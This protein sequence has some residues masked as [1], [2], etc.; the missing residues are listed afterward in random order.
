VRKKV[1]FGAL[2]VAGS[3]AAAAVLLQPQ[4]TP[5][6]AQSPKAASRAQ[7]PGVAAEE[8]FAALPS[9]E[10][11]GRPA[12]EPFGSHSWVPP[13]QA[14]AAAPVAVAPS[15]PPMPYRVAGQMV[16]GGA[17]Q[18][19]LAKGDRVLTVREGETL[20][21]GYRVEAIKADSV[22]LLYT[23]MNVRETLPFN[24]ALG[25]EAPAAKVA[26]AAAPPAAQSTDLGVTQASEARPAQLRWEG[27]ER[28]QAGNTFNVALKVTSDQAVRASPLQVSYDAALLE[29]VG[30]RAG[31]FF[32]GGSFSY[33]IVPGG[34]IMVGALGAGEVPADAE[35]LVVTFR[36]IRAGATADVKLSSVLLQG[37]AGRAIVH[38][39]PAAFRTA[40]Q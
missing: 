3:A 5:S 31:G 6:A 24:S 32:A 14:M 27:P 26:V 36:P 4:P 37:A 22:T 8:R 21:D 1:I 34:S 30:V 11:M 2:I 20:E 19:V 35:F 7:Q 28:V 25:L 39:Q 9:R 13:R 33:R 29:P 23:P 38:A 12:G 10:S 40:I 17:A 15:A 16:Q 18:V